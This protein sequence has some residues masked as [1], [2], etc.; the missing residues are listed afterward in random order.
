MFDAGTHRPL[1]SENG[2]AMCKATIAMAIF[3]SC[4]GCR[5]S[6]VGTPEPPRAAT[7]LLDEDALVVRQNVVKAVA[8][9]TMIDE[10]KL[11]MEG[12][13]FDCAFASNSRMPPC[14]SCSVRRIWKWPVSRVWH[15][16]LYYDDSGVKDVEVTSG[17]VGP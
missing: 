4:V 16:L 14:L 5:G 12:A 3:A 13:G 17:L 15:V 1:V 2:S 9:G 7:I 6:R 8:I 10:A 11:R